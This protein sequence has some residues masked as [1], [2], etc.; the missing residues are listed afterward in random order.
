MVG[1]RPH[2]A[3]LCG[4]VQWWIPGPLVPRS[5]VAQTL[6][7]GMSAAQA[8]AVVELSWRRTFSPVHAGWCGR[9]APKLKEVPHLAPSG[10]S[11]VV[12]RRLRIRCSEVRIRRG[13]PR[14]LIFR[15]LPVVGQRRHDNSYLQRLLRDGLLS[16]ILI[17]TAANSSSLHTALARRVANATPPWVRTATQI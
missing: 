8:R 1:S 3:P 7:S 11:A 12:G 2:Q 14:S 9:G 15:V 6:V 5:S 10:R 17:V 16:S 4:L 13:A